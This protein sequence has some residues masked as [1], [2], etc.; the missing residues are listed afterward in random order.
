[1]SVLQFRS[2]S[3]SPSP[4]LTSAHPSPFSDVQPN[5]RQN[6]RNRRFPPNDPPLK[7]LKCHCPFI[8]LHERDMCPPPVHCRTPNQ[9]PLFA[10]PRNFNKSEHSGPLIASTSICSLVP[11]LMCCFDSSSRF[12]VPAIG[13]ATYRNLSR[14]C[15]CVSPHPLYPTHSSERQHVPLPSSAELPISTISFRG[16]PISFP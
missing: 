3:F 7:A 11:Y 9:G 1:M 5:F 10:G 16:T 13:I 15:L 4:I 2:R 14:C 8:K 6:R 12:H